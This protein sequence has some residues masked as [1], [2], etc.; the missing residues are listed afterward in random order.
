MS[1]SS[2]GKKGLLV[3]TFIGL[4]LGASFTLL[5]QPF[6][7]EEMSALEEDLEDYRDE[8]TLL[9]GTIDELEA[10]VEVI[11]EEKRVL[12]EA[13]SEA[14]TRYQEIIAS[15]EA[16]QGSLLAQLQES[17]DE[18]S[19]LMSQL[20]D[21]VP[22]IS[23]LEAQIGLA[24][25]LL[26]A[27]TL[28]GGASLVDFLYVNVPLPR[29]IDQVNYQQSVESWTLRFT[30]FIPLANS[31]VVD[32]WG[33][34]YVH[35]YGVCPLN[36]E[37]QVNLDAVITRDMDM[38]PVVTS[39]E[40][41][42]PTELLE[43]VDERYL[44]S[45]TLYTNYPSYVS[46]DDPIIVSLA[47]ELSDGCTTISEVVDETL[48]WISTNVAWGCPSCIANYSVDPLWTLE[49]GMGNCVNFGYLYVSLFRAQGIPARSV[50]C[51]KGYEH[52]NP[53]YQTL[54]STEGCHVQTEI[55]Y[56]EVGWVRYDATYFEHPPH[57][58]YGI[59]LYSEPRIYPGRCEES[60]LTYEWLTEEWTLVSVGEGKVK[61]SYLEILA[62]RS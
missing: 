10:E 14:Q 17:E 44:E 2:L 37:I 16:E 49:N 24:R 13:L 35:V 7:T 12:N 22:T 50:T 59:Q 51:V 31:T 3:G 34:R 33:N 32:E 21:V 39:D 54:V 62:P 6:Q 23:D 47:E 36:A 38:E 41:P 15:S 46:S 18:I 30:N 4:I 43:A 40:Y 57:I 61:M 29:E 58:P 55:Y 53:G 26:S 28:V 60:E 19:E 52:S 56:P 11:K 45:F 20:E 48:G 27:S 1:S 8:V 42:I 9:K 5:L 25:E